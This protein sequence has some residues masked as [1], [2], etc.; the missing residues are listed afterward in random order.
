[1]ARAERQQA[2]RH[3]VAD[4]EANERI[5]SHKAR[6][7]SEDRMV[8]LRIV[9]QQHLVALAQ[10]LVDQPAGQHLHAFHRTWR[11]LEGCLHAERG[12]VDIQQHGKIGG[13]GL[14]QMLEAFGG[15]KG[16][17]RLVNTVLGGEVVAAVGHHLVLQAAQPGQVLAQ[18]FDHELLKIDHGFAAHAA[19][20]CLIFQQL[21]VAQQ[22]RGMTL[23]VIDHLGRGEAGRGRDGVVGAAGHGL[24]DGLTGLRP[25]GEEG[26][27]ALV[28]QW[29]VVHM[30]QNGR[31]NGRHVG[32]QLG[33][34]HH[35]HGMADGGDQYLGLEF[36]IGVVNLHDVGDQGH[37]FI[38]DIVEPADKGRDVAGAG[39]GRED[40]LGGGETECDVHPGA[41]VAQRL[42]GFESVGR[43]WNLDDDV[44]GDLGEL[45]A[46]GQHRG[47]IQRGYFGADRPGDDRTD[48]LHHIQELPAAFGDQRGIGGHAVHEPGRSEVANF[49]YVSRIDEKLHGP[50]REST[51]VG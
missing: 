29:M 50:H 48:F 11:I 25:V 10:K 4:L 2:H 30:A 46:L 41:F 47:V 44:A 34:I 32:A 8:A 39:F 36:R 19:W 38:A 24:E 7:R 40:R 27:K 31:R 20:G 16:Q 43:Q 15:E 9:A 22:E 42:A 3:V 45:A 23:Q 6:G 37:A 21:R 51:P 1:M 35:M 49:R 14:D 26:R 17:C 13:H 18:P 12:G 33:R 28:G 5:G